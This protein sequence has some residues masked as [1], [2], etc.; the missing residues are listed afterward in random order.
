[1][2]VIFL[3][4][5]FTDKS[6]GIDSLQF[7]RIRFSKFQLIT[8]Y[9]PVML[10]SVLPIILKNTSIEVDIMSHLILSVFSKMTSFHC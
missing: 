3:R 8:S 1:M 2:H 10:F 6:G 9:S 4:L 5:Q 7:Q